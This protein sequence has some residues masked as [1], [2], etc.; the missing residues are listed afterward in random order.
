MSSSAKLVFP[1]I[2]LV[3]LS[4]GG[5]PSTRV[6][7]PVETDTALGGPQV[8][9]TGPVVVE[10]FLKLD[11]IRR[12]HGQDSL[13]AFMEQHRQ[14]YYQ[15]VDAYGYYQ[16]VARKK[17]DSLRVRRVVLGDPAQVLVFRGS[18]GRLYPVHTR[19][20]QDSTG[21]F[22]FNGRDVPVFWSGAFDEHIP[23]SLA[24]FFR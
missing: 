20:Y 16:E 4:C 3:L 5:R 23:D 8:S 2:L 18:H 10:A 12:Q 15:L 17:L 21:V 7:T 9:L 1:V 22:L 13:D 6:F 19:R 24:A 11:M 14:E